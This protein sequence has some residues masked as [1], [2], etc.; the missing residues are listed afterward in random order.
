MNVTYVRHGTNKRGGEGFFYIFYSRGNIILYTL[1]VFDIVYSLLS[2]Q[3]SCS[4]LPSTITDDPKFYFWGTFCQ[5]PIP[6]D[7]V[8]MVCC[9][10][11]RL[12]GLLKDFL[13]FKFSFENRFVLMLVHLRRVDKRWEFSPECEDE[14]LR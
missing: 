11:F 14:V 5:I 13:H 9:N 1:M 8:T 12:Q 2:E 7:V 4:V 3:D 10:M 6:R